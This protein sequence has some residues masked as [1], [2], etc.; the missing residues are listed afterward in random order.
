[1][2]KIR[3]TA[4]GRM[5][6]SGLRQFYIFEGR[7]IPWLVMADDRVAA[8]GAMTICSFVPTPLDMSH[9]LA[10]F[11][12]VYTEQKFRGRGCA[13]LLA[14]QAVRECK[15]LGLKRVILAASEA[16]RPIYEKLGFEPAADLM[17]LF[18]EAGE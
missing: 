10:Y 14:E 2:N 13:K 1:M 6:I 9:N 7:I 17:R 4:C 12:S 18:V 11:H 3:R 5:I 16:G 8:S 15:R